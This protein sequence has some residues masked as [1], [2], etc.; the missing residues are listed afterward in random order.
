[1]FDQKIIDKINFSGW[2]FQIKTCFSKKDIAYFNLL[3]LIHTKH[4]FIVENTVLKFLT[5]EIIGI[6]DMLIFQSA[7]NLETWPISFFFHNEDSSIL[8]WYL[9]RL[10]YIKSSRKS[11]ESKHYWLC[12][13]SHRSLNISSLRKHEDGPY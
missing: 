2:Y 5:W 3:L 4:S 10:D 8:L 11:T 7:K 9:Y 12:N 13:D 6:E 1:M